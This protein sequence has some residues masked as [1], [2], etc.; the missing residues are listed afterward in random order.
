MAYISN[1]PNNNQNFNSQQINPNLFNAYQNM[2]L[3]NPNFNMLTPLQLNQM[4]MNYFYMNPNLFYNNPNNNINNNRGFQTFGPVNNMGPGV[5]GGNLPRRI[6]TDFDSYP[7]YI[8]PRINVIF[9]VSTGP[10]INI[11]APPSETVEGLLIKFCQ[12]AGVNPSLLK[13][14]IVCVYNATFINPTNKTTI[15]QFLLN[16]MGLNDQAKIIVIDA[17]NIIGA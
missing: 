10:K 1:F 7:G 4:L 14:E 11:A 16:N 13:K 17:Q 8:G 6:I 9:E 3:M 15:Q 5:Q 12:R 2:F